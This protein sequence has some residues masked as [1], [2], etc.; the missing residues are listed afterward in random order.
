MKRIEAYI[1]PHRLHKVIDSLHALPSFPGFTVLDVHGQ[2]QGR[3]AGGHYAYGDSGLLLHEH[4]MLVMLCLDEVADQI[5]DVIATAAH[6]GKQGDGIV[7]ISDVAA[8]RRI[9]DAGSNA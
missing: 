3:G 9:R 1:Q 4:R 2:G 8:F 5:A 7:A 6:T